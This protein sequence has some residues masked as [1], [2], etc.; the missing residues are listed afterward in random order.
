MS[1][2]R[3]Y[4]QTRIRTVKHGHHSCVERLAT[5]IGRARRF[6]IPPGQ[7]HEP[8]AKR[9]HRRPGTANPLPNSSPKR[10][11]LVFNNHHPSG[12]PLEKCLAK[13]GPHIDRQPG[14][15]KKLANNPLQIPGRHAAQ[16]RQNEHGSIAQL[17]RCNFVRATP[18]TLKP[19]HPSGATTS[20]QYT[21]MSSDVCASPA[22]VRS[23]SRSSIRRPVRDNSHARARRRKSRKSAIGPS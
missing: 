13:S 16:L 11:D 2:D 21:V 6:R 5:I 14:G 23:R 17:F 10:R 1:S 12:I 9:I 20:G 8:P 18:G 19:L 7:Y 3:K 15:A 4:C 22:G